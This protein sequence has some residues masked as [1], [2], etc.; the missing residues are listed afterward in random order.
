MIN[1]KPITNEEIAFHNGMKIVA[2]KITRIMGDEELSESEMLFL[3]NKELAEHESKELYLNINGENGVMF[4]G[5]PST[6]G[7]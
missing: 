3:I 7:Y 6:R 4:C 1:V 2:E 5:H